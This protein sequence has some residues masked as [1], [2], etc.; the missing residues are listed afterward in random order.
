MGRPSQV[1]N[2]DIE[3]ARG[4]DIAQI[5]AQLRLDVPERVRV[6]V[7]TANKMLAMQ[8]YA[9]TSSASD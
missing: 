7:A 1:E 8:H 2:L 5:R 3:D 9:N 4:V 6:M